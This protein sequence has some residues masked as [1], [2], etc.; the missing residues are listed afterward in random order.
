MFCPNCGTEFQGKFCPNCGKS[1]ESDVTE[2]ETTQNQETEQKVAPVY[3]GTKKYSIDEFINK[4][5]EK[6]GTGEIFELENDYLLNI[7]VDGKVW[8]KKGSMVAYS[9]DLKFKKEGTFEHGL[10]KFVKKAVTGES[11]TLMKM[12][13]QGKVY[14]ADYGKKIVILDLQNERIFVK[15]N[16]LLAFEEQIDW[17]IKMMSTGVGLTSGAGLF[18]IRLEGTGMVAITTYFTP[19]TLVVTPDQ[20]IYTDPQATV[21]WSGGLTPSVKTDIG[22]KTLIGK[23]S[24]E[25]FQLEFRGHGFVIVQPYEEIIQY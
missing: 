8:A 9:G 25:E 10:D 2:P 13:G 23:T 18:H 14:L 3:G 15:G 11:A 20:P 5:K 7:N 12:E 4:T 21:A 16:D 24:G 22:L 19:I 1:I 6:T 17:D